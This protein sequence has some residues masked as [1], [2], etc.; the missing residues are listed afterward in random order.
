MGMERNDEILSVVQ[1]LTH[2]FH[3]ICVNVGHG[4]GNGHG[5]VDDDL[6]LSRGL[7]DIDDLVADLRGKLGLRTREAFGRIFKREMSLGLFAV[8]LAKSC[9]EFIAKT[10]GNSITMSAPAF[11]A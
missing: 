4:V 5:K 3:L 2:I 6:I 7:P 9:A 11:I 10:V 1:M 8:L